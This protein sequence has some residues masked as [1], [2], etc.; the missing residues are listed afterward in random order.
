MSAASKVGG[1]IIAIGVG[2]AIGKTAREG[3]PKLVKPPKNPRKKKKKKRVSTR[4]VKK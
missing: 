2:S 3:L 1:G 4:R